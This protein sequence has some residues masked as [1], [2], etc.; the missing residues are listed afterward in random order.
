MEIKPIAK[1]ILPPKATKGNNYWR[2]QPP[3]APMA[4]GAAKEYFFKTP[5]LFILF[6][7]MNKI[8]VLKNCILPLHRQNTFGQPIILFQSPF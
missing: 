1:S 6:R 4:A 3:K 7:K 5:I 8:G 2:R